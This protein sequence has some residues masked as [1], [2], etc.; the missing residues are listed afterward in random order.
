MKGDVNEILKVVR[1]IAERRLKRSRKFIEKET[2]QT[3]NTV[4]K[5]LDR[6]M[7]KL[8]SDMNDDLRPIDN[9]I[10]EYNRMLESYG[11][12]I[13]AQTAS[14]N[15]TLN[16][17]GVETQKIQTRQK[18]IKQQEKEV[19]QAHAKHV[20]SLKRSVKS[21]GGAMLKHLHTRIEQI[22]QQANRQGAGLASVLGVAG[23]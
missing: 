20:T 4:K 11:K 3:L 13:V 10:A 12:E 23:L 18:A 19:Q 14:F 9:Q 6:K 1:M 8:K 16:D 22:N 21:K 2:A 7:K 17:I 5:A 15:K